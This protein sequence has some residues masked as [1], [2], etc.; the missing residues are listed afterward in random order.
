MGGGNSLCRFLGVPWPELEQRIR[1]AGE[2]PFTLP[3]DE[4][5]ASGLLWQEH[6]TDALSWIEALPAG[7]TATEDIRA[8][9]GFLA[10]QGDG[11]AQKALERQERDMPAPWVPFHVWG[12]EPT[13]TPS[14]WRRFATQRIVRSDEPLAE[15]LALRADPD[16]EGQPFFF[17]EPN[18]KTGEA[19]GDWAARHGIQLVTPELETLTP[20]P[21]INAWRDFLRQQLED[22]RGSNTVMRFFY[23][24]EIQAETGHMPPKGGSDLI[25]AA[26]RPFAKDPEWIVYQHTFNR[27][28]GETPADRYFVIQRR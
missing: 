14:R 24:K 2:D 23:A 7:T 4:I 28:A 21:R 15:L 27:H 12:G 9:L 22:L 8:I 13:D 10:R 3:F 1:A 5:L 19:L 25:H 16:M 26:L 20:D 6:R 18:E 11:R 17:S